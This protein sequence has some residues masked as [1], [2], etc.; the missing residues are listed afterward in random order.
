MTFNNE[1]AGWRILS[2]QADKTIKIIK[3]N[4]V[5]SSSYGNDYSWPNTSIKTYLNE[6]YYNNLTSEA[7]K[8]ITTYYFNTYADTT[9]NNAYLSTWITT[10][11]KS[12]WLGNIAIPNL[13]E[14]LRANSNLTCAQNIENNNKYICNESNWMATNT[15]YWLLCGYGA[16]S[17][18]SQY[19]ANEGKIYSDEINVYHSVRPT[20]YLSSKTK[21]TGGSGTI[22]DPYIIK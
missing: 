14:Y 1:Q 17:R 3:N 15:R 7:K 16:G 9:F 2:I 18:F 8:Q 12:T 22:L 11:K 4:A 6:D 21:I 10:E 20:L 13:S 5:T 19:V